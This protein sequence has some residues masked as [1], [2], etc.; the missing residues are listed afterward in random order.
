VG[1]CK[2]C[3]RKS[4]GGFFVFPGDAPGIF[5]QNMIFGLQYEYLVYDYVW[6]LSF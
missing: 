6:R 2:T 4:G 1:V 3:F 5:S